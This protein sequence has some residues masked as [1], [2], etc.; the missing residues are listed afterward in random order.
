MT[1][2]KYNC[3]VVYARNPD[4]TQKALSERRLL[5]NRSNRSLHWTK[6]MLSFHPNGIVSLKKFCI[7]K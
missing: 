3:K 4:V 2:I 6:K 7:N 5:V 1:K